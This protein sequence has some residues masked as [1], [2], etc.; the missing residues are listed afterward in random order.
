MPRK[1][2]RPPLKPVKIPLNR[3]NFHGFQQRLERY[4]HRSML[5]IVQASHVFQ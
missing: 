5:A 1:S 2:L 4:T 3:I